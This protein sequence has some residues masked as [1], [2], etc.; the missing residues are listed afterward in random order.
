MKSSRLPSVVVSFFLPHFLY[1]VICPKFCTDLVKFLSLNVRNDIP[2][3][4]LQLRHE[5]KK[6]G[7][8]KD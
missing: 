4:V 2:L 1:F 5:N 7:T 8:G 6:L 3:K